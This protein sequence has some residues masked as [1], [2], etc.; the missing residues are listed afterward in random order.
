M[1]LHKTINHW[2]CHKDVVW[3][4]LILFVHANVIYTSGAVH[5]IGILAPL[6]AV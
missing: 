3:L 2:S 1:V 4:A 6:V 5:L